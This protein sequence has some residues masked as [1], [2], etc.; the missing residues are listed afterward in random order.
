MAGYETL[1]AAEYLGRAIRRNRS[2]Y[3]R[4]RRAE[5]KMPCLKR[6]GQRLMARNFDRQVA[7]VQIPIAVMNGDTALG[8]PVTEIMK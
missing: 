4:R 7:E 1:R 6:L 2:G 3:H 5:T 8:I